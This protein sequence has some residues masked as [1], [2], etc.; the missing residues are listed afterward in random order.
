MQEGYENGSAFYGTK[1]MLII[2][3]T[4]GW[5]LFG[6]RNKLIEEMKGGA[7]LPAHHQNFLDAILKGEKL[8]APAE[9][10]HI[11]AGICHLANISTRLRK[12]IEFDPRRSRSPTARRPTRCVRRK[13]RPNHWAVPKGV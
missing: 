1:G 5:K 4:V 6:E 11:S 10:G 13:Y 7:D 12:T 9:V 2:G 3:H 8:A